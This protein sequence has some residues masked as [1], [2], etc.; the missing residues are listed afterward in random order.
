MILDWKGKVAARPWPRSLANGLTQ[1][2]NRVLGTIVVAPPSTRTIG[3]I[4]W[5]TSQGFTSWNSFASFIT[6]NN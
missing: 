5:N 4:S 3:F 1:L 2:F 6:R